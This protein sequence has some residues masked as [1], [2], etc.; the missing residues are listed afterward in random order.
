[1]QRVNITATRYHDFS[2][3]HRVVGHEGKCRH[4]HGHNYRAHFT[5]RAPALDNVGR[6]IDFGAIK[7]S[8]CQWLE[9]HWD[10]RMVIWAG[11]PLLPQLHALDPTIAVIPYNPTAENMARHL[12]EYVGPQI[13]EGTGIEL[14][15]VVLEETRKCS[16]TAE[17]G[18]DDV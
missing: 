17:L 4:L 1:M 7:G 10:H 14:V 11:D 8:L 15:K 9:D 6:V 16:A 12:L 13:L 2:C 18:G 5:C 3:G